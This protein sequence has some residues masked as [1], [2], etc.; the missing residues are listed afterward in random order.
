[1]YSVIPVFG[2]PQISSHDDI[3]AV[4]AP[5]LNSIRTTEG[6]IS[7]WGDDIVV[8][9]SKIIAKSL[10]LYTKRPENTNLEYLI[11]HDY[12]T[13]DN[14]PEKLALHALDDAHEQAGIVR[15]GLAARFGGR[16]GVLITRMDYVKK[17]DSYY[18]RPRVI[19]SAGVEAYS[20]SGINIHESLAYIATLSMHQ[21]FDCPVVVIRGVDDILTYED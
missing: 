16:P 2:I 13:L 19:G 18:A 17:D 6:S 10:G 14:V 11:E 8:I 9:S 3:A 1:M 15:K 12:M 5:A 7:L 20:D 4:I 21:F